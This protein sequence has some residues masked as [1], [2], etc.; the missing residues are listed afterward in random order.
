[1]NSN[2]SNLLRQ[3]NNMDSDIVALAIIEGDDYVEAIP[4]WEETLDVDLA[5]MATLGAVRVG[6]PVTAQYAA[7][8]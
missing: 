5:L 2:I 4:Y 6:K 3:A 8:P 7:L 1:M